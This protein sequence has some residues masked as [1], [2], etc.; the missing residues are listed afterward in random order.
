M[1]GIEDNPDYRP[2]YALSAPRL[3]ELPWV[4]TAKVLDVEACIALNPDL[5]ILPLRLK[6]SAEILEELGVHV[7]LVNPESQDLLLE[8]IR[9]VGTATNTQTTAEALIVF[10]AKQESYLNQILSG[11]DAPSVYLAGNSGLL[12]TPET[13]CISPI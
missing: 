7:L 3:L 8:M 13:L 11:V 1:V 10:L 5:V 12:T 4:G 6:D 9:M 2:F